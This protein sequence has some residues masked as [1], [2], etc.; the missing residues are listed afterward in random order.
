[1]LEGFIGRQNDGA[2]LVTLADDLKEVVGAVLVNGQVADLIEGQHLRVEV[3]LIAL[4]A[5]RPT[6]ISY[7]I[8]AR[9]DAN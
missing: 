3:F 4:C 6:F 1:M 8:P 2:S 7:G 9:G 5:P